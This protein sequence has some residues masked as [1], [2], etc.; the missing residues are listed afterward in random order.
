MLFPLTAATGVTQERISLPSS[1]TEQAPHCARPQPN[2]GPCRWSSLCKTYRRGV[3]R[4]ACTPCVR[5]LT[6]IL[7]LFAIHPPFMEKRHTSPRQAPIRAKPQQT[8]VLT[9]QHRKCSPAVAGMAIGRTSHFGL[10]RAEAGTVPRVA[11]SGRN[12]GSMQRFVCTAALACT[13]ALLG[14]L[15]SA[16]AA[17][18]PASAS[19]G[20]T[21]VRVTFLGDSVADA[22][23]YM[24]TA[25]QTL[26][27]GLDLHFDLRVC[28][29]LASAGCPYAG[30]TPASALA[31]VLSTG[32]RL[33]AVLVVDV[34]YND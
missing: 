2:R 10:T 29:R 22:L 24:P 5:P 26:G 33:G 21:P 19:G 4:L 25:E 3:S 23:S 16:C 9:F 1:S 27:R 6:L 17:S 11:L 28:R 8:H 32:P 18:T 7:R 20:A 31:A 13:A 15:T 12:N 30:A 34:G 14:A